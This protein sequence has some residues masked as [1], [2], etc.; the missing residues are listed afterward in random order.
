MQFLIYCKSQSRSNTTFPPFW[1]PTSRF[2]VELGKENCFQSNCTCSSSSS[3]SHASWYCPST[4]SITSPLLRRTNTTATYQPGIRESLKTSSI[5]KNLL[6]REWQS[7]FH[8]PSG[9]DVFFWFP[10]SESPGFQGPLFP[11]FQVSGFGDFFGIRP[12]RPEAPPKTLPFYQC[13]GPFRFVQHFFSLHQVEQE[14]DSITQKGCDLIGIGL[15][16]KKHTKKN[17]VACHC[18]FLR[19]KIRN[20]TSFLCLFQ[21]VLKTCLLIFPTKKKVAETL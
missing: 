6:L 10:S 7:T 18:H 12:T 16:E 1:R 9:S 14:D 19:E 15:L 13:F 21:F 5:K 3:L 2:R 11:H 8:T 20:K 4:Y 17:M